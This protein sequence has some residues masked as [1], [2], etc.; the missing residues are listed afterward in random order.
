MK[1]IL[2]LILVLCL[3]LTLFAACGGQ[4]GTTPETTATPTTQSTEPHVELTGKAALDGKKIIF[5]GN[6]YTFF[7]NAVIQKN[8]DILLQEQRSN[9]QGYFYQLCKANG[10]DVSV[11]NW[12]YGS[13]NITDMFGGRCK[14]EE[15]CFDQDHAMY[16][17]EP[18]F[19]YV[20]IQL[21]HERSGYMGDLVKHLS[22]A[23]DFFREAN[24]NVK[25]LFL[26]P[27]M[28]HEKKLCL[29]ERFGESE[30]GKH[31]HL[32]LGRYVL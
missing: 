31:H 14:I 12:T 4:P 8:R 1:R 27:H 11:T 13:H 10:V 22:P 20:A 21:F 7:G 18:Y 19:D 23:L 25:F 29:A 17:T 16:L 5:I 28:A 32:R 26:V 3:S 2:C 15:E 24:P 6:S 30:G 9:D